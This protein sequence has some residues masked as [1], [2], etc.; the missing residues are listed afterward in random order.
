MAA[1]PV[2]ISAPLQVDISLYRG[3]TGRFRVAVIDSSSGLPIDITAAT[4]LCQV[5]AAADNV[6]IIT[7]FIVQEVVG[8]VHEVDVI[9]DADSSAAIN[10]NAV[11][12]LEMMMG[13]L[14]TA[15][16]VT[17]MSGRIILT[18]DVSRGE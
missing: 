18:K 16:I 9:V 5:R 8:S 13:S 11:W 17:L 6:T 1:T 7:E 12:D 4:W 14:P 15:E 3:D 10:N 2:T